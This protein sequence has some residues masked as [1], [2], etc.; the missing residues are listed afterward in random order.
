MQEDSHRDLKC[1][2]CGNDTRPRGADSAESELEGSLEQGE[3]RALDFR[4]VALEP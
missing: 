4:P 3:L 2:N 1:Q